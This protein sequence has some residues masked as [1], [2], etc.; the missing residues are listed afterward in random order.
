MLCKRDAYQDMVDGREDVVESAYGDGDAPA[1][2][3]AEDITP[4]QA[5]GE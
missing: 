5:E 1:P 2:E 3:P 4:A